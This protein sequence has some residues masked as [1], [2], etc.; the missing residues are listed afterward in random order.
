MYRTNFPTLND[1]NIQNAITYVDAVYP[2]IFQMFSSMNQAAMVAKQTMLENLMVA[3]YLADSNPKSVTGVI[4]NGFPTTSKTIGGTK[5][6]SLT[7]RQSDIQPGMEFLNTN[8]FGNQA[9]QMYMGSLD[10]FGIYGNNI[11]GASRG[12]GGG[13]GM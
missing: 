6:V 8:W 7:F 11:V 3:W 4:A 5:G 1:A 2:G 13:L 9:I 12:A 10:R